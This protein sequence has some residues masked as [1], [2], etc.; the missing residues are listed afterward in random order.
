M[1]GWT[2]KSWLNFGSNPDIDSRSRPNSSLGRDVRSPTAPVLFL[3]FIDWNMDQGVTNNNTVILPHPD[4]LKHLTND[5]WHTDPFDLW[6][7]I[8][9]QVLPMILSCWPVWPMTKTHWS[10][11]PRHWPTDPFYLWPLSYWPVWPMK[12]DIMT[13]LIHDQDS[14]TRLTMTSIYWPILPMTFDRLTVWPVTLGPIPSSALLW[15][16]KP[17]SAL[18]PLQRTSPRHFHHSPVWRPLIAVRSVRQLC[19]SIRRYRTAKHRI[20]R[21]W[22]RGG[23]RRVLAALG[24]ARAGDRR[25]RLLDTPATTAAAWTGGR[26][27]AVKYGT[28]VAAA[29]AVDD[30]VDRRVECDKQITDLRWLQYEHTIIDINN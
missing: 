15:A 28:K 20:S 3:N 4:S 12:F 24:R 19:S 2:R 29:D 27:H 23:R 22:V 18:V 16:T 26:Q 11:W 6:P 5:P 1:Y 25:R 14:V 21:M 8:Y 10:A 30:E 9:W 13:R 17:I 7:L